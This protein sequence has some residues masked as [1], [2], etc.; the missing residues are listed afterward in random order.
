MCWGKADGVANCQFLSL[1]FTSLKKLTEDYKISVGFIILNFVFLP[2]FSKL[3]CQKPQQG[4]SQR[5]KGQ[6]GIFFCFEYVFQISTCLSFV[7]FPLHPLISLAPFSFLFFLRERIFFRYFTT[8]ALGV[9][10]LGGLFAVCL[11]KFMTLSCSRTGVLSQVTSGLCRRDAQSLVSYLLNLCKSCS[12]SSLLQGMAGEQ[13][14]WD[15]LIPIT[16]PTVRECR[17]HVVGWIE[18][19]MSPHLSCSSCLFCTSQTCLAIFFPN[20]FLKLGNTV[21]QPV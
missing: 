16:S 13:K 9:F 18:V 21:C 10:F 12:C 2:I 19:M 7:F 8:V 15:A 1:V 20:C 14:G 11:C 17:W 5:G 4:D 6:R 3:N